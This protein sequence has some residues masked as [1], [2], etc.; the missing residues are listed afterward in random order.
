MFTLSKS[1]ESHNPLHLLII[2]ILFFLSFTFHGSSQNP[3]GDTRC[4]TGSCKDN[5]A[6]ICNIPNAST[7]LDGN[8]P[9]LGGRF[10]DE[11]QMMCDGTNSFWCEHGGS[12][13]EIVQGEKY[14]CNCTPGFVGEHCEHSGAPCGD[15]F[16]FHEAEC[17][18]EDK[19]CGCPHDWKG[20]TDCSLP[21]K[22]DTDNSTSSSDSKSPNTDTKH[23]TAQWLVAG[24]VVSCSVGAAA[25]AAFYANKYF[26]KKN[27]QAS[28]FQQLSRMQSTLFLDDEEEEDDLLV[29]NGVRRN[30]AHL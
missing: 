12:C 10:C 1:R 21:T 15:M 4:R 17:L 11:E 8:R 19:E 26:K 18:V 5:G 27:A 3:C 29:N 30:E 22:T 7:I 23:S 25:L 2:S 20:S 6:C 24:L 9:F 13:V 16:C 28:K 14:V